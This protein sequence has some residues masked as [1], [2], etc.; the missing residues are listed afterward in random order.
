ML[1]TIAVRLMKMNGKLVDTNVVIRVLKGHTELFSLFDDM[2]NLY[3]SYITVG[4]L[5]YG[6]NLSSKKEFNL[7]NYKE[8]CQQMQLVEYEIKVAEAYGRIKSQLKRDGHPIPENDIWI[9]AC[10]ISNNLTVVTADA[11]F[12]FIK[13]LSVMIL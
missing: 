12:S 1:W 2:E 5:M 6:A 9:A 3:V 8:F 13:G 7:E 4:E 10:A 11:H